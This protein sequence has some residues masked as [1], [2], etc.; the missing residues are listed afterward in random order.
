V[1][2]RASEREREKAR[3]REKERERERPTEGE[4]ERERERERE[5]LRPNVASVTISRARILLPTIHF[6]GDPSSGAND[7]LGNARSHRHI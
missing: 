3:E 4:S 5:R 2:K 7:S 6:R 1:S